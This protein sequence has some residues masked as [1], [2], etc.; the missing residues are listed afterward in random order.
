MEVTHQTV[1]NWIKRYV[2]AMGKYLAQIEPQG[3]NT[4]RADELFL[5][6]KG[7]MKYLYAL[8]NDESRFWI[9]KEVSD[10]KYTADITPIFH[11]AK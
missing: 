1:Y 10:K 11:Q 7:N 2:S 5:K 3:G 4:W 9:A 8:L 6:V